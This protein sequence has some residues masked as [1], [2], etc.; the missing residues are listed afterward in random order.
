[1]LI[2]RLKVSGLL[3]FGPQGIRPADGK[4]E[5]SHRPERFR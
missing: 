4:P 3:S 1:M 2:N 5:C